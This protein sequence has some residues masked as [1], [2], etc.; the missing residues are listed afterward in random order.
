MDIIVG[1][2]VMEIIMKYDVC[3]LGELL[4]DFTELGI[5]AKG[6]PLFEANPGGAPANVLSMVSKLDKKAIF[7][8]KVGNDFLGETLIQRVAECG[9]DTKGVVKDLLTPTTLAFVHNAKDGERSFSFYRNPGADTMLLAKEI[10][11]DIIKNSTLFHFGTLSMTREPVKSTTVFAVET[12][13]ENGVLI[14]FDPNLR[15]NLWDDLTDAK[16]AYEYGCK[17][18]DILKISDNEIAFFENTSDYENG[19]H[20]I[21]EKYNIPLVFAT[22]GKDGSYALYKGDIVKADG[23]INLKTIDTTGAG[24]TFMGTALSFVLDY[25]LSNLDRKKL[26]QILTYANAA[27]SII[28]TRKGALC[29]MPSAKEI[30]TFLKEQ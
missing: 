12:A 14:S 7:M 5:G 3:A 21:Q 24:D 4:V 1:R 13:K 6:N 16:A 11:A 27:A 26:R 20:K 2:K 28:T 23:F 19:I 22:L 30:E 25:G 15:K 9:I 18:C 8:G 10:D 29:V 17:N